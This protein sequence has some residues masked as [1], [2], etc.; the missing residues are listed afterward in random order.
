M[1][2]ASPS[3]AAE[4]DGA[5]GAK[6]PTWSS[7]L[8][9]CVAVVS[10]VAGATEFVAEEWCAAYGFEY[11]TC[12]FGPAEMAA[13]RTAW[14]GDGAGVPLLS[15]DA[16]NPTGPLRLVEAFQCHAWPGLELKRPGG[17]TD[18]DDQAVSQQ[19][20]SASKPAVG[21]VDQ[22]ECSSDD[23]AVE[24]FEHIAGEMKQIRAISD[25]E[26]RRERAAEMA[27]R[28]AKSFGLSDDEEE[29]D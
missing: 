10:S 26:E 17:D 5:H 22:A 14:H 24:S 13:M 6:H 20:A 8:K 25:E 1:T 28:L 12:S 11:F 9:L 3:T 27:T 29:L 18:P 19:H 23:E 2:A 7:Q 21:A 4:R 15:A 16:A